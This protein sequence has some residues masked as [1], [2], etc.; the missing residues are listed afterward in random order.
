MKKGLFLIL[1]VISTLSS[2][3]QGMYGFET[4]AGSVSSFGRY[5]TPTLNGFV[6]KKIFPHVYVGGALDFRYFSFV[7]NDGTTLYSNPNYGYVEKVNHHSLYMFAS[8]MVDIAIGEE[9]YIHI[10]A[11]AGPG[12]ALYSNEWTDY[13]SNSVV[14]AEIRNHINTTDN[15]NLF[16]YQYG[17][18]I[19]EHIPVGRYWNITLSQQYSILGRD[20]NSGLGMAPPLKTNYFCVTI[21]VSRKFDK[22]YDWR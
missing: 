4:G 2:Y 6:I 8:P 9:E 21:G 5:F 10:F 1:L 7:Y 11:N 13:V 19:S 22:I 12:L 14:G 20:L 16:V 17:F 3:S 18:G 15:R